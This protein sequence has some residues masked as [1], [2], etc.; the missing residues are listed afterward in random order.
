[1]TSSLSIDHSATQLHPERI[2]SELQ[3]LPQWVCRRG[4]IPYQPRG[5]ALASSTDRTTWGTFSEALVAMERHHHDGIGFVFT[6]EDPYC[7]VD[8]D[9]CRDPQTGA[10]APW[11]AEIIDLFPGAYLEASPSGTGVHIIVRGKAPH[12]GKTAY[13]GGAV[14]MYDQGRYF[15]ITGV[16]L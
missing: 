13:Q 11:A 5:W 6:P 14:E 3:A 9:N 1:M 4:K 8:L 15:T 16:A 7:G 10:L 2:P 12:N